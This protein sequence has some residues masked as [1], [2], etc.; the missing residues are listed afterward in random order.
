MAQLRLNT[1]YSELKCPYTKYYSLQIIIY[2][3]N[4]KHEMSV[5]STPDPPINQ[6]CMSMLNILELEFL[7]CISWFEAA[8]QNHIFERESWP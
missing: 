1:T 8:L 5:D 7:V 2:L 3:L 4:I 6:P